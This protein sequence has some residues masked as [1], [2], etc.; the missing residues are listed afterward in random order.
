MLPLA[1]ILYSFILKRGDNLTLR[2]HL[3]LPYYLWGFILISILVSFIN[4]PSTISD[5]MELVG[6]IVLTIAMT[7]IG[8]KVGFKSL[9]SSGRKAVMFGGLVFVL[10]LILVFLMAFLFL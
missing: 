8:L 7:A 9:Y 1:V 6:K 5:S 10:Q 3:K 2:Q 4:L